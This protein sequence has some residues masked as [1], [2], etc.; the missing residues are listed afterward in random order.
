MI[1]NE[2]RLR[3]MT[4]VFTIHYDILIEYTIF[5]PDGKGEFIKTPDM[6]GMTVLYEKVYLGK[7]PIM[8]Q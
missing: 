5:I 4:Y 1:P 7:F 8:L 2:A 6:E 3:N